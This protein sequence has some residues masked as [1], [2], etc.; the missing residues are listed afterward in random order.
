MEIPIQRENL[1]KKYFSTNSRISNTHLSTRRWCW[2]CHQWWRYFGRNHSG[3]HG[4]YDL[5]THESNLLSIPIARII[6]RFLNSSH[7]IL[8]Q[9]NEAIINI[10]EVKPKAIGKYH[11]ESTIPQ[12]LLALLSWYSGG[13]SP[14][15]HDSSKEK[16]EGYEQKERD[17]SQFIISYIDILN[18]LLL[19]PASPYKYLL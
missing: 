6:N 16:D 5:T 9:C 11:L 14:S 1:P 18:N 19:E 8:N 13:D 12:I 2:T 17:R 4:S 15:N 10:Y 7:E 3:S